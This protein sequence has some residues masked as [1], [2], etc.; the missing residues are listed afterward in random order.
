MR[1]ALQEQRKT[2][3]DQGE[4]QIKALRDNQEQLVNINND[5]DYKNKLLLSKEREIFKN[6]YKKDLIKWKN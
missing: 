2:I 1:K 3:K 6:I 5:E 4:K